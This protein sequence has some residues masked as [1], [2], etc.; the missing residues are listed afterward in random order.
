MIC[1]GGCLCAAVRF[2]AHAGP[3][4][5]SY[6]HCGDCRRATGAP[7][8]AF[9]GFPEEMTTFEGEARRSFRAGSIERSFCGRCGSPLTYRDEKLPGE[10]YVYLGVMNEP[11]RFAPTLHAFESQRLP[12]LKIDDHLPRFERF[13]IER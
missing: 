11:E 9:V 8:A 13:S 10:V 12:F 6:C 4:W 5:R 1:E 7:V 3:I 2:A